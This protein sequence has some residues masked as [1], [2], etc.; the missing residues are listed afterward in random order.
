MSEF[1]SDVI[2]GD[3]EVKTAEL[4]APLD[5]ATSSSVKVDFS[6]GRANVTA[7]PAVTGN[8]FEANIAYVGE[9]EFEVTGEAD[10][11]VKLR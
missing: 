2:G 5:G 3:V 4:E 10:R 11:R 8:L 7:L 1:F 6:V 9:Y